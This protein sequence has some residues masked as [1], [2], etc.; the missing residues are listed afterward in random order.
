MVQINVFQTL[1]ILVRDPWVP[2]VINCHVCHCNPDFHGYPQY[3]WV[4]ILDG[5]VVV[6]NGD[7]TD[8]RICQL[9]L[10]FK[11]HHDHEEDYCLFYVKY[12]W[13]T[14]LKKCDAEIGMWVVEKTDN[15]E[16]VPV[17]SVM[18]YVY[19]V[20]FFDTWSSL[21]SQGNQDWDVYSFQHYLINCYSDS[22]AFKYFS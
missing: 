11:Y 1:N 3:D 21:S 17:S 19:L 10:I 4:A 12:F 13:Y 14:N 6:K 20:P 22:Y 9:Q 7:T 8:Y 2:G 15:Y 18:C 16:V 5:D